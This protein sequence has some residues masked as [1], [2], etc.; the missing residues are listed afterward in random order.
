MPRPIPK[1]IET[2]DTFMHFG[3]NLISNELKEW[4]SNAKSQEDFLT[5]YSGKTMT[6]W[7]CRELVDKSVNE[8]KHWEDVELPSW[9]TNELT[10]KKVELVYPYI[11]GVDKMGMVIVFFPEGINPKSEKGI[12][13]TL[14]MAR[15]I[16]LDSI[17]R[18][19][20][21]AEPIADND[22]QVGKKKGLSLFSGLFNRNKAS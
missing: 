8:G 9:A 19:T 21:K 3:S 5:Y 2:F 4:W 13:V 14:E 12:I 6:N 11:D 10:T 18:N 22:E 20:I 16:L 7:L 17:Q 15:T 1:P